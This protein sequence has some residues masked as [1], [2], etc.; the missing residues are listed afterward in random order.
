[1]L[2]RY[3]RVSIFGFGQ[4]ILRH[5]VR[6]VHQMPALADALCCLN[7]GLHM[8]MRVSCVWSRPKVLFPPPITGGGEGVNHN[9]RDG[10]SRKMC[11]AQSPHHGQGPVVGFVQMPSTTL[12]S[13]G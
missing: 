13:A 5:S 10:L 12:V 11:Q 3:D 7:S 4:Y 8:G 6:C 9:F 1:M 2:S